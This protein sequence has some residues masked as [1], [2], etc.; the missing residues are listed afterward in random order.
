[1]KYKTL[2]KSRLVNFRQK[3]ES[4]DGFGYTIFAPDKL[5]FQEAKKRL[6]RK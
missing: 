4:S 3:L 1:M 6:E 2:K 5:F